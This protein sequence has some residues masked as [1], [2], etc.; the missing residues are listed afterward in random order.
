V[1]YI[2]VF[3]DKTIKIMHATLNVRRASANHHSL[4]ILQHSAGNALINALNKKSLLFIAAVFSVEASSCCT[5]APS[6]RC[7]V[8][9]A[10]QSAVIA[11]AET[12]LPFLQQTKLKAV[13]FRNGCSDPGLRSRRQNVRLLNI[14]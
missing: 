1:R 13:F 14:R 5:F 3:A 8:R 9:V 7:L 12:K 10:Y 6:A 4:Q 11:R 2:N